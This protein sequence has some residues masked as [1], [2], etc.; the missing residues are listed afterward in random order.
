MIIIKII[1]LLLFKQAGWRVKKRKMNNNIIHNV[2]I[3]TATAQRGV[4]GMKGFRPG[5]SV[6]LTSVAMV[7][8][9]RYTWPLFVNVHCKQVHPVLLTMAEAYCKTHS[10]DLERGLADGTYQP[11]CLG[12]TPDL[13]DD[14][15]PAD[16]Q[17]VSKARLRVIC[18]HVQE[19]LALELWAGAEGLLPGCYN[20]PVSPMKYKLGQT[21]AIPQ[22]HLISLN[23]CHFFAN[24]DHSHIL[25]AVTLQTK[26]SNV[27]AVIER[28]LQLGLLDHG[29]AQSAPGKPGGSP[30]AP[31]ITNLLMRPLLAMM[32]E[33]GHQCI[34]VD[35]TLLIPMNNIKCAFRVVKAVTKFVKSRL[36]AGNAREMTMV[37]SQ[38]KH[39]FY[40]IYRNS[41][42]LPDSLPS[43]KS[44]APARTLW[45]SPQPLPEFQEFVYQPVP[46][47]PSLP[48]Q[49]YQIS[50]ELP[51]LQEQPQES[52]GDMSDVPY[53]SGD[54]YIL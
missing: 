26:N 48:A 25:D 6:T 51:S 29:I 18:L 50:Q 33:R 4:A 16:E 9:F 1:N 24:A 53:I 34:R 30:L 54:E 38:L 23:L 2:M 12:F 46:S 5:R 40:E 8:R 10:D 47:K 42:V 35:D 52:P 36:K 14:F 41:I 7:K 20:Y 17:T 11:V 37:V 15:D 49:P 39:G 21:R 31:V 22:H 43:L 3:G 28:Y 45:I 19:Y 13:V 27:T 44:S 32:A